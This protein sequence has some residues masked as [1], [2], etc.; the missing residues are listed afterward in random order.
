MNKMNK[1]QM[2]L[3]T[4]DGENGS[5]A[6]TQKMM[7][8]MMPVMFGFFSFMYTASFSIYMVVSSVFSLLSTL[9]INFLVEKGFER[10]AAKE[11]HEL[12]LKRTGRIKELEESKNNKKKK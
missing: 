5:S 9:L 7:T 10:Q 4:V 6:M 11:A 1:S 2:E 12:E 3:S 8:W